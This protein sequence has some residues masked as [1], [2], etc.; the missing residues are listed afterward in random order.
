MLDPLNTLSQRLSRQS[1]AA[2]ICVG[3]AITIA[4]FWLFNASPAPFSHPVLLEQTGVGLLDLL[5]YYTFA[6]AYQHLSTLGAEGR[7]AYLLF[8]AVDY[9]FI[10]VYSLTAAWLI[11]ALVRRAFGARTNRMRLNL[12]PLAIGLCD[13]VENSCNLAQLLAF[14]AALPPVGAL[15][16]I[17]TLSKHG[18][19]LLVLGLMVVLTVQGF[20]ARRNGQM[21]G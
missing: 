15:A 17:A 20:R 4:G 3:L 7:R 10:L 13:V 16:G 21:A 5:P 1:R 19:T 11:S 18:A 14:P 12:A 6:E 9:L 8:L 2:T